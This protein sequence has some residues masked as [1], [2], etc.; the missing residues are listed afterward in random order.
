MQ[1]PWTAK[2]V[3]TVKGQHNGKFGCVI[4]MWHD[5]HVASTTTSA[6]VFDTPEEAYAGGKRAVAMYAETALFPNMCEVF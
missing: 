6:C 1:N 3:G 5:E 4:D 2:L